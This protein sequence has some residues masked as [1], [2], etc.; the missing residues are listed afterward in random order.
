MNNNITILISLDI[1]SEVGH[2]QKIIR[3]PIQSPGGGGGEYFQNKYFG[4]PFS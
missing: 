4:T 2:K 3:G 1:I